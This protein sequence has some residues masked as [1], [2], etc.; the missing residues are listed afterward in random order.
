M[1]GSHWAPAMCRGTYS[2][3]RLTE[4]LRGLPGQTSRTGQVLQRTRHACEIWSASPL[5]GPAR[6][7]LTN[8]YSAHAHPAATV[9]VTHAGPADAARRQLCMRTSM[10]ERAVPVALTV[11]APVAVPHSTCARGRARGSAGACRGQRRGKS[12]MPCALFMG[13]QVH[14]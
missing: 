14:A 13:H 8:G 2:Q 6:R 11:Y 3:W 10:Y 4:P 12:H 1:R 5:T 7:T 9:Q